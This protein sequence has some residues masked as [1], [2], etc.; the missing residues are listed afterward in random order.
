MNHQITCTPPQLHEIVT[1]LHRNKAK[2]Q[3]RIRYNQRKAETTEEQ[4]KQA[5]DP[6]RKL[7]LDTIETCRRG[8]IETIDGLLEMLEPLL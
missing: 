7:Y 5:A 8:R 3:Q 4:E 2:I 6:N 1:A